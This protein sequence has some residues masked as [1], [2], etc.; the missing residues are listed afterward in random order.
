MSKLRFSDIVDNIRFSLPPFYLFGMLSES[1]PRSF[2]F[3]FN[4]IVGFEDLLLFFIELEV[5]EECYLES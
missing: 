2:T 1:G 4:F 3:P 5:F